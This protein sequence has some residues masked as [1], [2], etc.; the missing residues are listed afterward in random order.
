MLF[1]S[2]RR[3]VRDTLKYLPDMSSVPQFKV[4]SRPVTACSRSSVSG[5]GKRLIKYLESDQVSFRIC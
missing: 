1:F 3:D 2:V 5:Q 4:S